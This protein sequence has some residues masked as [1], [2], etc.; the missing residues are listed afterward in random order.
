MIQAQFWVL[1]IRLGT[2]QEE[3]PACMSFH[4]SSMPVP[5][6]T[7]S[8]LFGKLW[9]GCHR[10]PR[11]GNTADIPFRNIFSTRSVQSAV[12]GLAASR[13]PG[14]MIEMQNLRLIPRPSDSNCALVRPLGWI[15]CR[16]RFV[17][18]CFKIPSPTNTKEQ[19]GQISLRKSTSGLS[20]ADAESQQAKDKDVLRK[21]KC[22]Q[23][24]N[25]PQSHWRVRQWLNNCEHSMELVSRE[26]HLG[27]S[28][29]GTPAFTD[30]TSL[31]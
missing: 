6:F 9:Q 24:A 3:L 12:C 27:K 22:A 1:D 23:N 16:W 8:E 18:H 20:L 13:P 26:T 29:V 21:K 17:K 10:A 2:K 19:N 7:W 28:H 4:S 25:A 15:S 5:F 11:R 14:S 30:S 31:A